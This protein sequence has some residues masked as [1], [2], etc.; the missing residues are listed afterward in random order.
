MTLVCYFN[1][2]NCVLDFGFFK[3]EDTI[4]AMKDGMRL[5]VGAV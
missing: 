1:T 5:F 3:K 2:K 4:L